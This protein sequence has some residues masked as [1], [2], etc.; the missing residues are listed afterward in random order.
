M[1][2]PTGAYLP[3]QRINSML[4]TFFGILADEPEAIADTFI[5]DRTTWLTFNRLAIKAALKNPILLLWIWQL[6]GFKDILRWLGSYLDFTLAALWGWLLAGWVP[7][8]LQKYQPWLEA[9][10]PALWLRCLA[11]IYAWRT[12]LGGGSRPKADTLSL[13]YQ[14]KSNSAPGS[15]LSPEQARERS[16][17]LVTDI[18]QKS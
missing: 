17:T 1:M 5:K 6:A 7:Q 9:K 13:G 11:Q 2:V 15:P 18:S 12:G 4:N 10:F 3:P 8:L 14:A 16:T